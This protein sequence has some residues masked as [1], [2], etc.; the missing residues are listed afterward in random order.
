MECESLASVRGS[1]GAVFGNMLVYGI[2]GWGWARTKYNFNDSDEGALSLSRT[3][4]GVVG[5]V[6]AEWYITRLGPG[7]LVRVGE[8]VKEL[9][10]ANHDQH[11]YREDMPREC[12]PV[13]LL[14][15]RHQSALRGS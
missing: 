2:A 8:A 1:V 12:G 14:R 13:P 3:T 9:V 4:S 10:A 11:R 15:S 6:G 5:G 7:S